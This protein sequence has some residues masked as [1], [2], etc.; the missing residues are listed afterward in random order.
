MAK[1]TAIGWGSEGTNA[2]EPDYFEKQAEKWAGNN[3]TPSSVKP[4]SGP[5]KSSKDPSPAPTTARRSKRARKVSSTAAST[6]GSTKVEQ[7][8]DGD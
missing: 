8:P 6:V 7:A 3:S 1:V 2:L 4:V 5:E